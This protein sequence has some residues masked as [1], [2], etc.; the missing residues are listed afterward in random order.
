[1]VPTLRRQFCCLLTICLSAGL[2]GPATAEELFEIRRIEVS[3]N[4]LLPAEAIERLTAPFVGRDKGFRDIQMALEALEGAYR[5][6]GYSAVQVLTPEQEL[7]GGTL[8]FEIRETTIAR[9]GVAGNRHFSEANIRASLPSLQAGSSPN[10]RQLSESIQLANENPAKQVDVV[11][12]VSE[13]Q[14]GQLEATI[15]VEDEPPFRGFVNADNTGAHVT[16]RHRLGVGLRHSN[17][18]DRDHTATF[19]YTG[20]PDKPDGTKV[21]IYSLGYRLP[22]YGIGDSIDLFYAKSNI[23]TPAAAFTLGAFENLTGK[24]ELYGIRWNHYFQRRG[25]WSTKLVAGWDVKTLDTACTGPSGEKNFLKGLS[26][27]CTPYTTR[28]LSL[29]YSGNWQR[30]GQAVD[31]YAGAAY[32]V[33]TGRHNTYNTVDNLTGDDR[34][35]L[36]ANNRKTRDDFTVLR[37]GGSY[38]HVLPASWM[39]RVAGSMQSS[40]GYPLPPAEQ[41]GLAGAQTVRGFYERTVA[42]DSGYVVNLELYAPDMAP[43]LTLPG[44]LRPLLFVDAARGYSYRMPPRQGGSTDTE[45][46]GI[47]SAGLGLRYNYKKDVQVR[48]DV[49]SVL[50]AGPAEDLTDAS[51]TRNGD[52][53]GHFNIVVGF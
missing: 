27:G 28:P 45:P 24:G 46:A 23:D 26:A 34:Y 33:A 21:D 25:E 14:P 12:A 41:I 9:V 16:G 11:L 3:G 18:W 52:W 22:L 13:K 4:T 8:R 31:F 38:S 15:N 35:S 48:F 43:L 1:M 53:L 2:A 37:L 49:A 36:V 20:S 19:A 39:A 5:Q 40:L 42:A 10:T 47:M 51:K 50:D 17:L 30:P 7:T 44:N 32:N 6:A 29:T